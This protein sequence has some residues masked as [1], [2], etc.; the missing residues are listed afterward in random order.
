MQVGGTPSA[1]I[2][3]CRHVRVSYK[4][5]FVLG[6]QGRSTAVL[7]VA[8]LCVLTIVTDRPGDN[9][10]GR[11]QLIEASVVVL[12]WH[13]RGQIL[14]LHLA[15]GADCTADNSTRGSDTC[16]DDDRRGRAKL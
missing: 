4:R 3:V 1:W 12:L 9:H 2:P 13:T 15:C 10:V 6:E 5:H 8:T 14:A 16:S 11:S 7:L